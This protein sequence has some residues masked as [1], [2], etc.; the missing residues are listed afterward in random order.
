MLKLKSNRPLYLQLVDR[1][2]VT[3]KSSM[4]PNDKL[5]SERELTDYYGVSRITVR[6]ALQELE[7]RG[8]IY[9][10]H[11]KGTYVSETSSPAVDLSAAYSF[12]EQMLKM[13]KTPE[14]KTLSFERLPAIEQIAH[15][16]QVEPGTEIFEIERL[17]LADGVPMMLERSY[18]PADLFAELTMEQLMMKPLYDIFAEDYS[19]QIRLA[20]EEFYASIAL[21]YEAKQ[22]KIK[23]GSP[24]LHLTRKTYNS[25][26]K[27]IEYTFSMARSDQFRYK[28]SH[29]RQS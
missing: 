9:K 14:T 26:N 22:L 16:L 18:L 28:I 8:F 13:G 3:I 25:K 20:E 1:L 23:T 24:V 21:D 29:I 4:S 6:Q 10:K 7:K 17:R 19:Q 5:M 12:T 27:V 2:I 11:G 15:Y